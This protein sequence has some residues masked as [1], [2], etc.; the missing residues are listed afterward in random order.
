MAALL[1][2]LIKTFNF[3]INV[4]G[5]D[6]EDDDEED[7]NEVAE[8][9]QEENDED[10]ENADEDEGPT[11]APFDEEPTIPS[12][13]KNG[14]IPPTVPLERIIHI[15]KLP[16]SKLSERITLKNTLACSMLVKAVLPIS[17]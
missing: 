1:C 3:T 5:D 14:A 12:K 2:R 4:D 8:E 17:F 11:E 15:T 6:Q 16:K 7:D 9:E 13:V 10:D